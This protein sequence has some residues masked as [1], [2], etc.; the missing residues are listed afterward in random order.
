MDTAAGKKS[1][2]FVFWFHRLHLKVVARITSPR[3]VRNNGSMQSIST[4]N[5]FQFKIF[6]GIITFSL[7][8]EWLHSV[9]FL[10]LQS[11]LNLSIC[12][13]SQFYSALKNVQY[14]KLI[15]KHCFVKSG[16]NIVQ[17][18]RRNDNVFWWTVEMSSQLYNILKCIF[19]KVELFVHSIFNIHNGNIIETKY[20]YMIPQTWVNIV[21]WIALHCKNIKI[22]WKTA[23]WYIPLDVKWI[24]RIITGSLDR[25]KMDSWSLILQ[26]RDF[27]FIKRR[28]FIDREMFE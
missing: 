23:V 20:L 27:V 26:I 12:S 16:N 28:V 10:M 13:N 18:R 24:G 25:N 4:E 5:R 6:T 2:H 19:F 3:S 17:Q 8:S 7:S 21:R 9:N 14:R 1:V 11:Q 22:D 15:H